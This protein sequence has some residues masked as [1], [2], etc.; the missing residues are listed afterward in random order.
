MDLLFSFTVTLLSLLLNWEEIIFDTSLCS[1]YFTSI[2]LWILLAVL[3]SPS[4]Q[5]LKKLYHYQSYKSMVF[6]C[7]YRLT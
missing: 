2:S 3:I 1:K 5:K 6:C 7:I 4:D